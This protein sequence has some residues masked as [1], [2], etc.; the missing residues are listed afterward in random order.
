LAKDFDQALATMVKH[1]GWSRV[2]GGKGS[3]EK[4]IN[5][6]SGRTV[7]VPRSKSH[8]AD[9]EVL[10]QAGLPKAF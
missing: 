6:V 3:H 4:E 9:N 7:V 2:S 1:A 10:K 5:G 8:H